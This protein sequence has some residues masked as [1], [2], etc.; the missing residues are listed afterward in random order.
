MR[1]GGAKRRKAVAAA[2]TFTQLLQSSIRQPVGY[3][4]SRESDKEGEVSSGLG[5]IVSSKC[6]S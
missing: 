1:L 3:W 5:R 2:N 6:W 4:D